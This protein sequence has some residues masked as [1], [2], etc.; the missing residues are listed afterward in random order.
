[1][2]RKL[3]IALKYLVIVSLGYKKLKDET[4]KVIFR[5]RKKGGGKKKQMEKKEGVVNL[6][7]PSTLND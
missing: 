3:S 4:L 2:E 1:M 7:I 5:S 6:M